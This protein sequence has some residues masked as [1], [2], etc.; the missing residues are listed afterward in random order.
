MT[1][2]EAVYATFDPDTCERIMH[3]ALA[4]GDMEGVRAALT[5][6]APQDPHRAQELLDM[7]KLGLT[8]A[9]WSNRE[10]GTP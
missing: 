4:A 5:V 1:T 3:A 6:M 8:L 9:D 2:P 7:L 10:Q